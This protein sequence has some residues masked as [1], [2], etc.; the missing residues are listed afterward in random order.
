M[1]RLYELE[2]MLD[3]IAAEEE[4]LYKKLERSAASAGRFLRSL[5]RKHNNRE[6]KRALM[7]KRALR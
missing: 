1:S 7:T 6:M 3:A 5:T 2:D 4:Q